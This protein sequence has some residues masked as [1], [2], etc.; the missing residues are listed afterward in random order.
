MMDAH[1]LPLAGVECLCRQLLPAA[2][3]EQLTTLDSGQWEKVGILCTG[4]TVVTPFSLSAS[5]REPR[6]LSL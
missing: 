5:G 6:G 1:L 2:T 4:Q 3:P